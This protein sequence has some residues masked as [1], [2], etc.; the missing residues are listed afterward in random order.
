MCV[1]LYNAVPENRP[2]STLGDHRIGSSTTEAFT[3]AYTH[4]TTTT[5]AN[6]NHDSSNGIGHRKRTEH[7]EH[8]RMK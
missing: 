2:K 1:V 6:N 5:L 8:K 4:S 3:H 7:R